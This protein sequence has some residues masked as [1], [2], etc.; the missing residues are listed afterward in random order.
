MLAVVNSPFG[1]QGARGAPRHLQ[2][3][4]VE[5]GREE[6]RQVRGRQGSVNGQGQVLA[7]EVNRGVYDLRLAEQSGRQVNDELLLVRHVADERKF[8]R[9]LAVDGHVAPLRV[10]F[11]AERGRVERVAVERR[12]EVGRARERGQSASAEELREHGERHVRALHAEV[13]YAKVLKPRVARRPREAYRA[14]GRDVACAEP[15]V[16]RV[17]RYV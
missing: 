3:G 14:G 16:E 2:V 9:G 4:A 5:Y 10:Q 13:V 15:H 6:R 7:R 12:G 8:A 11:G 1:V 17:E